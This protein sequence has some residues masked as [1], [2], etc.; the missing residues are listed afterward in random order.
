MY[1]VTLGIL[2][3]KE[4]VFHCCKCLPERNEK[5]DNTSAFSILKQRKIFSLF[6]SNE[7]DFL[8]IN[9]MDLFV[10]VEKLTLESRD[11]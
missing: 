8:F 11:S 5:N 4:I 3:F 7:T 1:K 9:C 2:F 6:G 10:V